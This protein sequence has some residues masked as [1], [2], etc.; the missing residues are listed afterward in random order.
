MNSIDLEAPPVIARIVQCPNCRIRV[1]P[2]NGECPSCR[3]QVPD[4]VFHIAEANGTAVFDG[5]SME[6]RMEVSPQVAGDRLGERLSRLFSTIGRCMAMSLG[7]GVMY[8]LSTAFA[9]EPAVSMV[10]FFVSLIVSLIA[11]VSTMRSAFDLLRVVFLPTEQLA[12]ERLKAALGVK[13]PWVARA[14]C[15]V[16]AMVVLLWSVVIWMALAF[17][18]FSLFQSALMNW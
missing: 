7:L 11:G 15:C 1:R 9:V 17:S 18:V 4:E 8:G 14:A 16:G 6:N 5:D 13:N 10:L 3:N 2:T 12:S